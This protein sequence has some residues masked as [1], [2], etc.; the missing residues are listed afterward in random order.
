MTLSGGIGG[1]GLLPSFS[2]L[3]ADGHAVRSWDYK[4]RAALVVWLLGRDQP[5]RA[6]LDA[7]GMAYPRLRSEDAELLILRIGPP[8][9]LAQMRG[10][11]PGVLLAD[12]EGSVHARLAAT[13]PTLIVADRDGAIYWR[14]PADQVPDFDEAASWLAYINVLEPECGCCA[15]C[16]PDAEPTSA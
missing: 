5:S 11:L 2:L 12:P 8:E 1:I 3:D 16:W 14:A 4:G 6:A 13:G 7:C 9:S 10:G 15:P